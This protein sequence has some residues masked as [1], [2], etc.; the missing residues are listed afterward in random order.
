MDEFVQA[1]VLATTLRG[2]PQRAGVAVV[3]VSGGGVAHVSDIADEVGVP[4]PAF[5]PATVDA[6]RALLPPFASPQNPLDTTGIVFGDGGIYRRALE[7]VAADP[8]VGLVVAAQDAP[9]GLDDACAAEYHGIAQ[10]YAAFARDDDTP[11]L[12]MSNLSAGHHP[13]IAPL[14][15]GLPVVAGTRAALSAA[16]SLA[17][18][19]AFDPPAFGGNAR[20]DEWSARLRSG[21]PLTEREAKTL[22]A[23]FGLPVTQEALATSAGGAA[24]TAARIGFP[25]AMKIESPDIAHKTEAGG[26]RLGIAGAD[27]ARAAFEAIMS[28]AAAHDPRARLAGVLVQEMVPQ[29]VEAVVGLVR[30]EPFGLGIVVGVGGVLVELVKDAAFDLLPLDA[31]GAAALIARTRLDALLNGYRAAPPA[32]R[33]ALADVLVGLSRFAAAYGE[34]IEAVDLNP[35]VV[36]P[37][38][39]RVVDALVVGRRG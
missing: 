25:V 32:D 21:T 27:E 13:S 26:V 22:L 16:K 28:N 34:H 4:L 9:A 1:G 2:R 33:A 12:F 14:V 23:G 6:L 31:D 3:G 8:S 7:I 29:G 37:R 15:E 38:G 18:P 17:S 19:A 10:A 39:A 35:V 11:A 30:H 24:D 20:D 5:A 36:L